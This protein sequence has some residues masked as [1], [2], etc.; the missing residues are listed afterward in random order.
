VPFNLLFELACFG[1]APSRCKALRLR[2]SGE[3]NRLPVCAS[4]LVAGEMSG[5]FGYFNPDTLTKTLAM[6]AIRIS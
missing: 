6:T 4:S 2:D 5:D 3:I 1:L